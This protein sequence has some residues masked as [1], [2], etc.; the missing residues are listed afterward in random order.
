[1]FALAS[2]VFFLLY[3]LGINPDA[4]DFRFLAL[5]LLAAHFAGLS[6]Y[7]PSLPAHRNRG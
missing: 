5:A 4:I 1:M 7:T 3:A 2:A 6:E